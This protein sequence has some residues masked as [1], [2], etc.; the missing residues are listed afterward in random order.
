MGRLLT[1]ASDALGS[2]SSAKSCSLMLL[3]DELKLGSVL[4]RSGAR[5]PRADC[6]WERGAE[7]M[8]DDSPRVLM[9]ELLTDVLLRAC[10]DSQEEVRCI[11]RLVSARDPCLEGPPLVSPSFESVASQPAV[12]LTTASDGCGPTSDGHIPRGAVLLLSNALILELP[13]M[14]CQFVLPK[15]G[16]L[17]YVFWSRPA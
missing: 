5:R 16:P 10:P 13:Q 9:G 11:H 12:F 6:S 1:C 7:Y 3:N 17:L 14:P 15:G 4:V 8:S 2:I